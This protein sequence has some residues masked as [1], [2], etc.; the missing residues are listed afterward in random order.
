[1]GEA[2]GRRWEEEA[3]VGKAGD[4][5]EMRHSGTHCS[6][7]KFSPIPQESKHK[8]SPAGCHSKN[9]TDDEHW[10]KPGHTAHSCPKWYH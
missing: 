4:T 8:E 3:G 6:L 10:T 5:R 2:G 1:M 7:Q 9:G